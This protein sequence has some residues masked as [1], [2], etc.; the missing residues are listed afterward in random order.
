MKK[1]VGFMMFVGVMALAA[2]GGTG[3]GD[4]GDGE[5]C[6]GGDCGGG[7]SKM[8]SSQ[9][10]IDNYVNGTVKAQYWVMVHADPA[11]GQ[12]WETSGEAY[13]T[14]STQRWN[15]AKV[16]GDM[17]VIEW[18]M[19]SDSEY[20]MSDYVLAFQVDLTVAMGEV[21]VQ[22]AWIGKPGEAG[23]EIEVMAKPEPVACGAATSDYEITNEDF[24]DV[25]MAGGKWSGT[26]QT[27]KGEGFEMKTWTASNGW[28]NG[29][30]KTEM[31][32]AT[33]SELTAFGDDGTPILKG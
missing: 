22:K 4:G 30:I 17:A 7:S 9:M 25:E 5:S 2:C 6:G 16:D 26:L 8:D 15:V 3:G 14:T 24:T 33:S 20:A 27:I 21:N 28:F 12:Y 11:G 31:N 13:G 32:G 18:Q 1:F 10:M 19:K 23:A 29:V